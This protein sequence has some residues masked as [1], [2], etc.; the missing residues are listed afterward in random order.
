MGARME[1]AEDA[2]RVEELIGAA[3]CEDISL[4][5]VSRAIDSNSWRQKGCGGRGANIK[6]SCCQEDGGAP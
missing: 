6:T 4:T 3:A 2:D 1:I 5:K